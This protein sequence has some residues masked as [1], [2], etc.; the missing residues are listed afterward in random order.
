VAI[1]T[2]PD[3]LSATKGV[4]MFDIPN[5]SGSFGAL[6]VITSLIGA[7]GG[8]IANL[9]YPYFIQQ[10]GWNSP[11]F[12]K[13]QL[14]DLA[15][16]TII[17]VIINLSIWTIGAELLFPNNINI[18]NL[19]DLGQLLTIAIGK[20]GEPIFFIGVFSALYSSV[21][22][23]AVGFGFLITDI[24]GVMKS[25]NTVKSMPLNISNSKVYR[26]VVIWC[27]FT[28][29][30]WLFPNMPSFITLTLVA[31]TAAVIVLPILCGSLWYI[32]SSKRY[33]GNK[34]KNTI[35]E[36]LTLLILFILSIWGSYQ[37][38]F[39]IRGILNF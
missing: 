8:S 5:N 25:K 26:L 19:D 30:I 11:K 17:L 39:V 33:I 23:Y 32:T 36:H 9:L 16:G 20:Y 24:V 15:F 27:L 10:K 22:G 38:I 3:P 34:Y 18:K 29:L 13:V 21:I 2:G 37:A 1:W 28:P 31:N 6:L 14:Y 35:F 12:R 7:V 4:F